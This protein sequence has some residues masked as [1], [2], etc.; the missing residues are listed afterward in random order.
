M[1][2]Y[3][4]LYLLFCFQDICTISN[5]MIPRDRAQA[6]EKI[7]AISPIVRVIHA[8]DRL[9]TP[10]SSAVIMPLFA[11]KALFPGHA[12]REPHRP[13][14]LVDDKDEEHHR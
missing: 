12:L 4:C 6:I 14:D 11:E 10:L 3:K 9:L 1:K 7:P 13:R 2:L 8:L 5:Y